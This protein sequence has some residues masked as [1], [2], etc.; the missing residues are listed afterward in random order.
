MVLDLYTCAQR[1]RVREPINFLLVIFIAEI[2]FIALICMF[3]WQIRMTIAFLSLIRLLC[4]FLDQVV[5]QIPE[6]IF[7]LFMYI[8]VWKSYF[9]KM[10]VSI[11]SIEDEVYLSGSSQFQA[12]IRKWAPVA[13]VFGV[14]FLLFWVKTKIYW[15][16]QLFW[17]LGTFLLC[18]WW[19]YSL[20]SRSVAHPHMCTWLVFHDKFLSSWM[21]LAEGTSR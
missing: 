18:F 6:L 10:C 14:V 3:Y 17:K 16:N 5:S 12:L 21:D 9:K 8:C 13:I 7:F 1:E 20:D 4:A 11:N 19:H 15:S 2:I